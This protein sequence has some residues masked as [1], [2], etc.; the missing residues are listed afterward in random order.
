MEKLLTLITD[1][2]HDDAGVTS[3]EYALLGVLIAIAI[4]GAVSAVGD[5]V[6]SMYELIAS[7]MP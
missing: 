5:S 1:L 3:I 4:I 7:K 6:K 2:L